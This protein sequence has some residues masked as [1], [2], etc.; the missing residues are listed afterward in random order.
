MGQSQFQLGAWSSVAGS[1]GLLKI[2]SSLRPF[3]IKDLPSPN[4]RVIPC[5]KPLCFMHITC[6]AELQNCAI[7]GDAGPSETLKGLVFPA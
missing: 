1:I 5:D 4:V 6:L 7:A 2:F 3:I